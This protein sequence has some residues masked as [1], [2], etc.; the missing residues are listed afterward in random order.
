MSLKADL[1][2]AQGPVGS[3]ARARFPG[4]KQL[5][6]R[7]RAAGEPVRVRPQGWGDGTDQRWSWSGTACDTLLRW[8][9]GS[10][11][12][13]HAAIRGAWLLLGELDSTDLA[14]LLQKPP[15]LADL[16]A[17]ARVAV[18][19]A[20]AE[21]HYRY[22]ATENPLTDVADGPTDVLLAAASDDV[23]ADVAAVGQVTSA[24]LVPA[25]RA[26]GPLM[27]GPEFEYPGAAD[28]D[29]LA[30]STIVEVKTTVSRVGLIEVLQSIGYALLSEPGSVDHIAF[31]YP[32]SGRLVRLALDEV[33][34]VAAGEP[35]DV[36]QLRTELLEAARRRRW[37]L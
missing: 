16:Q 22:A 24:E 34:T 1:R 25:L 26:L 3:W 36:D 18:V 32:R 33:L 8:Q 10:I 35:I 28:G 2:Q 5:Y 19:W 21:Q 37:A 29:L 14:R 30:G 27:F 6:P 7:I 17:A 12:P 11:G 13:A 4:C 20:L 23:V 31:A 15:D 9:L